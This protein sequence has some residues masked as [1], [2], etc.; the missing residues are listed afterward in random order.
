MALQTKW[1]QARGFVKW[2][3]V[4]PQNRDTKS[5]DRK[6]QKM[7]DA[8]QG[9][10]KVD[11][12]PKDDAELDKIKATGI[13]SKLYGGND[14][15]K[16]DAEG[17]GTKV[18]LQLKRKHF[19]QK[20]MPD[21]KVFDFG[22]Q[23]EIVGWGEDNKGEPWDNNVLLG[24]GTEVLIKFTMYGEPEDTGQ[25]VRLEKIGVINLV[26]YEGDDNGERF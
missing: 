1:I 23:P 15:F 14:R 24:N 2:A 13:S 17:Y 16:V 5:T 6:V 21:G 8:S 18:Y 12:Y 9:I 10:Y 7:L 4:F 11:F 3:K 22:G 25:T 20:E 19:D 26:P